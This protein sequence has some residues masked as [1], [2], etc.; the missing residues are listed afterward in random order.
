MNYYPPRFLFRR[1]EILKVI[2]PGAEFL[3]IGCGRM[4]LSR[5][6]LASF[7][8][9]TI[10]DFN[11]E[12]RTVYSQLPPAVQNRLHLTIGDFAHMPFPDHAGYD[13]VL[14]CEVLEHV[15]DDAFFIRKMARLLKPGGRMAVSVPAGM[16]FWS[17][18]DEIVGHFRRYE[19]RD[20][21]NLMRETGLVNIRLISY[22]FPFTNLLRRLRIAVA[23]WQSGKKSVWDR[24]RRSKESSMMLEPRPMTNLLGLFCNPVTVWPFARM[25]SVYNTRDLSDG[26]LAVADKPQEEDR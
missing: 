14:A 7:A 4:L 11:E 6:L 5:D 8:K 15:A 10:V 26:Y 23:R 22:G 12:I 24:E 19:R 16:R 21:L 18:D 25:A 17:A 20:I 1:Y 2:R 9:G 3:E 13:C